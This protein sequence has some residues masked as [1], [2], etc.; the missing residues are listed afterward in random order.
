VLSAGFYDAYYKKA[1]Q[2]RTLIIED[3]DKAFEEVDVIVSPVS[4]EAA[5]KIGTKSTDPLKMYLADAYTIPP[6][7]A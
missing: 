1:S 2:I 4:P 6:S 5:W 7:L 3:F